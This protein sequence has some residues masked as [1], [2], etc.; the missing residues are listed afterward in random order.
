[1][2]LGVKLRKLQYQ[3]IKDLES[4]KGVDEFSGII[5][6]HESGVTRPASDILYDNSIRN[7][8]WYGEDSLGVCG[9]DEWWE[10][11]N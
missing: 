2:V 11:L 8:V 10:R 3:T 1:M 5:L 4:P 7:G 9:L 6:Q